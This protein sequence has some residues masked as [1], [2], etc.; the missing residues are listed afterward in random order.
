[1]TEQTSFT[2]PAPLEGGPSAGAARS[3]APLGLAVEE[4]PPEVGAASSTEE[5]TSRI[6]AT[7]VVGPVPTTLIESL[8][9][10]RVSG[11]WA[12]KVRQRLA[13]R[14]GGEYLKL[15]LADR[16]GSVEAKL[17]E[18]VDECFEC[19]APGTVVR[20]EGAYSVHPQFGAA[21]KVDRIRA[22]REGEYELDDLLIAGDVP[23]E[24]LEADLRDL[25]STIQSAQLRALLERVFGERSEIW[26]RFR[27]APAAK[28][29]HQAY[30]HGLLDHTLSVAQAVSA[31]ASAFSGVDREIAVTGALLHDIGKIQAYNDD[32]LAIDLTDAGRLQGE[33]PLG[34]YL[35]RRTVETIEGF[36]PE[37]AQ[38][39]FH[40]ILSH[41]GKLENGSPV[42]PATREATLVHMMDNLGGTL[43]SFDRIERELREGEVWSRF[44][45]GIDSAAYFAARA[46]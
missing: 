32:P 33:I 10:G 40:I 3:Q 46:A 6:Q 35:V 38:A 14:S 36:D 22:A 9:E 2:D 8:S 17:W 16:T 34:Y 39:I 21:I 30:R 20:V 41:H 44:D 24:R 31:A 19:A 45:R 29:Y 13:K 18:A 23:F 7:P 5:A 12:V 26:L 1:M 15:V 4:A 27:E 42:V 11:C 25:L 43:G 28:Y 37:L